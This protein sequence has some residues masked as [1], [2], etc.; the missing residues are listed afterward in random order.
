MKSR[1][2]RNI[3][4]GGFEQ[5]GRNLARALDIFFGCAQQRRAADTDGART[6]GALAV[7]YE[8]GVAVLDADRVKWHA[9]FLGCD[10]C[11]GRLVALTVGM[12]AHQ[13]RN[14]TIGVETDRST[15][16]IGDGQGPAGDFDDAGNAHAAQLAPGLA[17]ARRASKPSR[18]AA[19]TAR[20]RQA[21]NS[22]L[23]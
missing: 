10:L 19:A 23:S 9:E 3:V 20:S 5:M 15:F 1:L 11:K 7:M 14:T 18:S 17:S 8:I 12:R 6:E 22:P 2:K 4:F 16:L 13:H 21:S